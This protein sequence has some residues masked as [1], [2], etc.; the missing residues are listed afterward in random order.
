[1]AMT[2]VKKVLVVV[3]PLIAWL[4]IWELGDSIIDNTLFFTGVVPTLKALTALIVTKSFW[5]TVL[6]SM[7]RIAS[8]FVIGVAV[9]ILLAIIS[10]KSE[11]LCSFISQGISVIKA[12]PVASIIII[13]WIFV[14]RSRAASAI[15]LFMVAPI[16]WQNLVDGFKS[17]DKGL[18]EVTDIF[19]LK[20]FKR[21]RLLVFPTLVRYFAPAVLTSVGLAWK[22]GI[23]AEIITVAENSIGA[24]IKNNKDTFDSDY[25]L[26]WTLVVVIVSIIFEVAI[27]F[28]VR[29]FNR[30]EH[31]N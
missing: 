28:S 1:M 30:H 7:L 31:K 17:I 21:F 29:R 23:A 25:M 19:E 11:F 3:L 15:A 18:I 6:S 24:Q 22:S 10:S 14:G 13:L 26:A 2:K 4:L 9:G 16:I 27:K 20:G 8:G 12:T 5:L